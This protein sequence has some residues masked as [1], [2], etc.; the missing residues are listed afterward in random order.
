MYLSI[1][2]AV[3]T[4]LLK[5]TAY[6]VTGSIGF[7]SDA[8]ESIVNLLA[9]VFGLIMLHVSEKPADEGHE[10]GHSKAEYFSSAIEGSL[11][12]LAAFSIIWSAVPRLIHPIALENIN[13]GLLFSVGASLVNLAVGQMLIRNGKK[14]K[15]LLVEADGKHLMT[16][17]W[18]SAGVIAGILL[19][20][21]TGILI[22]D[23]IIAILVALNIVYTGYR[24][25]SRSTNGLMDASISETE[26][27]Q[28]KKYLD[29]L[30]EKDITY[31]SLMTRQAGQRKFISFHLLV[32]GAWTVQQGHENADIIEETIEDM[33][34]E[35]VTVTSHI[36]P[37][38][39]PASLKDI[40]IDRKKNS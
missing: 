34:D 35:P 27:D 19:V 39:D 21:F 4:I 17:V 24:L 9:A 15:S 38:E 31:H 30:K 2:A 37:V 29:S 6:K 11:I 3:V 25:I 26:I 22:L 40:G 23:P 13:I 36:E 18:T 32:P 12:L 14:S 28:V 7:F 8:L 5:F 10:F 16:D 33:F 1:A 20:K